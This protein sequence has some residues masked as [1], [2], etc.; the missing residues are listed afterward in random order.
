MLQCNMKR[1]INVK[2]GMNKAE[3]KQYALSSGTGPN[4]GVPKGF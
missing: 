2:L 3:A 4:S 1:I